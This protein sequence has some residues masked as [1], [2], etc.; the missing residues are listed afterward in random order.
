MEPMKKVNENIIYLADIHFS[1]V[2][3]LKT[4]SGKIKK[5]RTVVL[6]DELF[7]KNPGEDMIKYDNQIYSEKLKVTEKEIMEISKVVLK[8]EISCSFYKR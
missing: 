3:T 1:I 4:K 8:K 6:L 7:Q 5:I 2:K